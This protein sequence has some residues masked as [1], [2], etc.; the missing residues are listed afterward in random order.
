MSLAGF[1]AESYSA[2]QIIDRKYKAYFKDSNLVLT[3]GVHT[4]LI[5]LLEPSPIPPDLEGR[6][7]AL[8]AY[9]IQ[10]DVKIRALEQYDI[11]NDVK[12]RVFE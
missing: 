12:V 10:N 6:V 8:E 5:S 9:D 11:Q 3:D 1:A 7:E 4:L 2:Q